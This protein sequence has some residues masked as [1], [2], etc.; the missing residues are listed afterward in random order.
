[1][2]SGD[3]PP[4]YVVV[5]LIGRGGMGRVFCARDTRLE[6]NVALKVLRVTGMDQNGSEFDRAE[7]VMRMMR[8]ARAVAS[9]E[10]ANIVTIYD[11][12]ELPT[13]NGEERFCFIAMELIEG[14][15]LRYYVGGKDVTLE[16]RVGWLADVAKALAFA[17]E[18]GIIHRDI[19]PDNVM[20]RE[21]GVVKVLDFGLARRATGIVPQPGTP[22]L[23]T[24]T[25]PGSVL[26]TVLYM[27]PEQMCGAVLDGRA[28]QFS[29]GVIAY[30][31]LAGKPPWSGAADSI[32]VV[33][34]ILTHEPVPIC[35]LEPSVS[36]ALGEVVHRAIARNKED[37]FASMD[38]VLDALEAVL[39]SLALPRRASRASGAPMRR[40]S[41][42]PADSSVARKAVGQTPPRSLGPA[43]EA[44]S[45]RVSWRLATLAVAALGAAAVVGGVFW[46]RTHNRVR[47]ASAA[48]AQDADCGKGRA[49]RGGA[50]EVRSSCRSNAECTKTRGAAAICRADTG[51]C[52]VLAS[53]DCHVV[54]EPSDLENDATVWIGTMFPLVGDEAQSF[55]RREFQAV[56][57]ARSDFA[58][59]LHG[60][61][62]R[63]DGERVRP[64]A[65]VACDDSVNPSRAARHLV[66]NVGVPAIIGFRTSKEVIDLATSTFIPRGVLTVAALNT[67]P[68]IA[69]LP[70]APG[71]PRMVFRTTYSSAQA[72]APIG[73]LVS[74][75]LEPEIRALPGALRGNDP[76]RVALVRQDDAAGIGFAD[77]LFRALR[78][79]GRSALENESS[80]QEF[81]Y[82]F[83]TSDSKQ[84]DFDQVAKKVLSF[85]PHVI[86]HF[87]ADEAFLSILESLE[88]SRK[89]PAFRPRYVKPTALSPSVLAFIGQSTERRRRFL[90]ITSLSTTSANA[91]FVARY[92]EVYPEPVTRT[93]SPNSSYDAFYL[94]AYSTYALGHQPVTGVSL[95]RAIGRL[96]PPGRPIDV[97][98]SGIFDAINALSTGGHIDLN[99]ATG[100]LDFDI[101]TGEAPVDLTVLCVRAQADG[102][103]IDGVESGLSYDA[104]ARTLRGVMHC[105]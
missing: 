82:P 93:F 53:E 15:P 104:T 5:R 98:P 38:A 79:N 69:S 99:G 22:V 50:C 90:S 9:L 25:E 64:L 58:Y 78:F 102:T 1:M 92:S 47:A 101:E 81:A 36:P 34:Q 2:D 62:A 77:A 65:M 72:A 60:M 23:A 17:H 66:D 35:A 51:A 49:C 43:F 97:G 63:P 10:H 56:E 87:G 31:L 46:G 76:L 11:V 24:L 28:D 80:Y 26:G 19:K 75:V 84:P 74:D 96:L 100:G 13:G 59:M 88:R 86:I 68:V 12:G 33:A 30:E 89:T 16:T 6:R 105:P 54:A 95:A 73:L 32:Q 8:E 61:N 94:L 14:R 70:R 48:C 18:R 41:A 29:W 21:D 67:S 52:A 45:G 83:D 40:P 57:L 27:A 91:R 44:A 71:Q 3:L 37:R 85:A 20:I 7:S 55:G 4:R 39:P 103:A 42:S